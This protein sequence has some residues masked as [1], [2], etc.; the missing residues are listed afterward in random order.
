MLLLQRL[1]IFLPRFVIIRPKLKEQIGNTVLCVTL[2]DMIW[3]NRTF[4]QFLTDS[5]CVLL[6]LTVQQTPSAVV[7]C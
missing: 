2:N 5:I 4:P 1:F 7:L 3:A 6:I